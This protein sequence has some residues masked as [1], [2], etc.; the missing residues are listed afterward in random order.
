MVAPV[1]VGSASKDVGVRALLDAIVHYLPSPADLGEIV[2][3]DAKGKE[4]KIVPD[5]AGPLVARV[6]KTTADPFVGRLTYL[7]VLSGTLHGQG[8]SWNS[9]RGEPERI[10]QL[11]LLHGKDQET[12]G[13]LQAGEIGAVA[14]LT[15]TAT[16]RHALRHL[17]SSPTRCR[18]CRSPF[19]RC[20]SRSSRRPRP[21]STRWA[22]PSSACSK[23]SPPRESSAPR[24]A[25]RSS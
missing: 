11:L 1:L 13:Q 3:T 8:Q 10:G 4:V 7:R 15:V 23:R 17:A 14:K 16:G 9:T 20:R 19:R 12:V 25:S 2:A 22:R 21:T 6:F 5:A 18:L 24:P